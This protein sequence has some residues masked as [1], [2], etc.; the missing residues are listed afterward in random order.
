LPPFLGHFA[1]SPEARDIARRVSD[2]LQFSSTLMPP[3]RRRR[4]F[5]DHTL[6]YARRAISKIANA[7]AISPPFRVLPS[8]P[9]RFHGYATLMFAIDISRRHASRIAAPRRRATLVSR[10]FPLFHYS[11]FSP[12]P[13]FAILSPAAVRR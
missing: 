1:L 8:S 4:D 13:A 12:P 6:R 7:C 3:F 10:P 9:L 11:W 5:A 2:T